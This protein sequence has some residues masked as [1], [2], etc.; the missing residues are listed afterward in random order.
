MT[1]DSSTTGSATATAIRDLVEASPFDA[2]DWL[3]H[4]LTQFN[5]K[6]NRIS[7]PNESKEV[8]FSALDSVLELAVTIPDQ[9]PL[10]F[11]A[12]SAFV[13]FPRLALRSLPPSCKG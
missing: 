6:I 12:Y 7:F 4:E 3:L 9:D 1:R 11:S 13:L 5:V 2:S 8:I 10:A